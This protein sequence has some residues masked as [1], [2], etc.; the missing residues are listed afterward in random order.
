MRCLRYFIL[1]PAI[2]VLAFTLPYGWLIL[3]QLALGIAYTFLGVLAIDI[4]RMD[5]GK[6]SMFA[7][8]KGGDVNATTTTS[9][10]KQA[11]P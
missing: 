5:K 10:S 3:F 1:G 2:M 11:S 6:P 7:R 9:D 8:K 4:D